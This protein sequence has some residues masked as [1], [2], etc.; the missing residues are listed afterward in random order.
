MDTG[1]E[2]DRLTSWLPRYL[3]WSGPLLKTWVFTPLT[4]V[5]SRKNND[6]TPISIQPC[7]TV[8][9]NNHQ[10]HRSS[11]REGEH[12]WQNQD[13]S[14]HILN[15]NKMQLIQRV[16][17]VGGGLRGPWLRLQNR[18]IERSFVD[19]ID[20]RIYSHTC[21]CI[22]CYSTNVNCHSQPSPEF[23]ASRCAWRNPKCFPP[24]NGRNQSQFT[25]SITGD[26]RKF[27]WFIDMDPTLRER[28]NLRRTSHEFLQL[29]L[30][31]A[32]SGPCAVRVLMIPG[33]VHK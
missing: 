22:T 11:R 14:P 6:H 17:C 13:F 7:S 18:N 2:N 5:I 20:G 19:V 28:S 32:A 10:Y 29:T 15:K 9:K 16:T 25:C 12:V 33:N 30:H 4:A 3:V 24:W 21:R 31:R 8:R 23:A 27:W 1:A 26:S